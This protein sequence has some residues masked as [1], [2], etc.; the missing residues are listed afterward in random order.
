[1]ASISTSVTS[2]TGHVEAALVADVRLHD[3]T[4]GLAHAVLDVDLAGLVAGEGGAEVRDDAGVD[5]GLPLLAV[6]VLLALVAGAEVQQDGADLLAAGLLQGAV[7]DEGAEGRQAGAETGHDEGRLGGGGQLHDG[8]LDG[9][10]DGG[11]DGEGGEVARGVAEAVAAAG[12]DP[13]DDDDHEGDGV[14]GDGLGG[15]DGVLAAL[16][17][18]DDADEVV[19][20]GAGRGELLENVDVGDK[21][22][23]GALLEVGG[24]LGATEAGEDGLLALVRG[25]LGQGLVEA[26]G[27]LAEDVDVLLEG[28]VDGAGLEGGRVLAGGHLDNG[29]RVE[30]VPG[31]ELA[32]FLLVVLGVDA[33]GLANVVGEARVAEVE[34]DVEDVAV[35]GLGREAAV[36][37]DGDGVR[38]DGQLGA[39]RGLRAV[40]LLEGEALGGG[41]PVDELGGLL[42]LLL[43]EADEAVGLDGRGEGADDDVL[44]ELGP[45]GL[46]LDLAQGL[47]EGLLGLG[48]GESEA[49]GE[50]DLGN[51][52]G[53]DVG[54]GDLEEGE[55]QQDLDGLRLLLGDGG[56]SRVQDA[57][58][59]GLV[60]DLLE[61]NGGEALLEVLLL[62]AGEVHEQLATGLDALEDVE[63]LEELLLADG[64]NV[65]LLDGVGG[66]NGLLG[67]ADVSADDAALEKVVERLVDV[68]VAGGL[69][70]EQVADNGGGVDG[71]GVV[72]VPEGV[73]VGLDQGGEG[74]GLGVGV[75][76]LAE[77]VGDGLG[78][79][80]VRDGRVLAPLSG[81]G[82]GGQDVGVESR[83]QGG[84]VDGQLVLDLAQDGNGPGGL[85]DAGEEG[86][87]D[88]GAVD[89]DVDGADLDAI[90]GQTADDL[91]REL[92]L[93]AA[94]DNEDSLGILVSVVLEQAVGGAELVVE[95]LEELDDLAG[96]V[97]SLVQGLDLARD[98]LVSLGDALLVQGIGCLEGLLG[99]LDAVLD[100]QVGGEGGHE[101]G[102]EGSVLA[103][104]VVGGV[105]VLVE[106]IQEVGD[107]GGDGGSLADA[108][109]L[110]GDAV[111]QIRDAALAEGIDDTGGLAGEPDTVVDV[112]GGHQGGH[113]GRKERHVLRLVRAGAGNETETQVLGGPQSSVV[114]GNQAIRG[115]V[116]EGRNVGNKGGGNSV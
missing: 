17:R 41:L 54:A 22:D 1:M 113:E 81:E 88:K 53:G 2:G 43:V 84:V 16:E 11:A 112:Q 35:V 50:G 64:D 18:G 69:A 77:D 9:G 107:L 97:E 59:N 100:A 15:G 12:V 30:A 91:L 116:V 32:D 68:D 103:L 44:G 101:G 10:D 86:L 83:L 49:L 95:E 67:A 29:L 106:D 37:L 76:E 33:E 105:E 74:L 65:G 42:G 80:D 21:V 39:E 71:D 24:A 87:L 8:G 45:G 90:S 109:G 75:E 40:G 6:Q 108:G 47:A 56:L 99:Q 70:G 96:V 20:R 73:L 110:G 19:E 82:D 89:A 92:G 34:L 98:L 23:L 57:Q 63:V 114:V 31:D 27:R 55:L 60:P 13:V 46:G 93:G 72:D 26:L 25:E 85:G 115:I 48:K 7:L 102:Q 3:V 52:L 51:L 104:V 36:L 28:L 61:H 38:L 62:E 5:V 79:L 111:V 4:H 58:L 66:L 14:G 78:V 94:K